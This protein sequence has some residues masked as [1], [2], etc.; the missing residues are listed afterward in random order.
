MAKVYD[1][2]EK[3]NYEESPKL[4]IKDVEVRL[5]DDAPTMLKVMAKLGDNVTPS[6]IAEMYELLIPKTD[7]ANI[8][9]L[10]LNFGDF[11]TVVKAAI[12]AVTGNDIDDLD[13]ADEAE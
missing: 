6:D 3:L 9:K 4:K 12:A 10:K 11:Q 5:N 2:T 13:K 1:I 8:D 7:R